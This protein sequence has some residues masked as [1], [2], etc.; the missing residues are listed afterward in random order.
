MVAAESTL[1]GLIDILLVFLA[2]DLLQMAQSGPGILNAAIG[3]GGLAGGLAGVDTPTGC[4]RAVPARGTAP[5]GL[6][7]PASAGIAR[8]AG[9]EVAPPSP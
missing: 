8:P 2:L 5:A 9:A 1:V 7:R 3:A 4:E 6:P